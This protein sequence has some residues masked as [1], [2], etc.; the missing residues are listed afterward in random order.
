MCTRHVIYYESTGVY[1]PK[2]AEMNAF[3]Q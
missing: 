1:G 3:G 2:S